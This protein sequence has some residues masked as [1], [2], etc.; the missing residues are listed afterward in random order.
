MIEH[1]VDTQETSMDGLVQDLLDVN[2][3]PPQP[4]VPLN[5]KDKQQQ[6][7]KPKPKVK[8]NY[9]KKK[10][11]IAVVDTDE[12]PADFGFKSMEEFHAAKRIANG[13]VGIRT[14]SRS[15]QNHQ[16]FQ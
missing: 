6:I 4:P 7:P 8:K 12:N 14:R 15:S 9:I 16:D 5:F 3:Q 2:H 1:P 10:S 13:D 11:N